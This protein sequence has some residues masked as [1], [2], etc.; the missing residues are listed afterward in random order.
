MVLLSALS[1][2]NAVYSVLSAMV[3]LS[4][5]ACL[6]KMQHDQCAKVRPSALSCQHSMQFDQCLQWFNHHCCH[7]Y[8][9]CSVPSVCKG[10]TVST[11]VSTDKAVYSVSAK[12]QQPICSHLQQS[13]C[14]MT[15]NRCDDVEHLVNHS[16]SQL[17]NASC[18][19]T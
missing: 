15:L 3:Q 10:S 11:I 8:R 6:Q 5:L 9:K 17:I 12:D 7:V 19:Y 14:C 2:E 18:A 1:T 13:P 4:A 16:R